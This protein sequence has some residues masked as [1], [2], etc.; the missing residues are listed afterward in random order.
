[1]IQIHD[2]MSEPARQGIGL[3][4]K[5]MAALALTAAIFMATGAAGWRMARSVHNEIQTLQ[6]TLDGGNSAAITEELL[7]RTD[8]ASLWL[9][10]GTFAGVVLLAGICFYLIR[11]VV[12]P[13]RTSAHLIH[14]LAAG[15]DGEDVSANQLARGDEIAIWPVQYEML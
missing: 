1:M 2:A 15:D 7:V 5:L 4:T 9:A 8:A 12:R 10:V 14:R 3:A 6:S 13:V 11:A